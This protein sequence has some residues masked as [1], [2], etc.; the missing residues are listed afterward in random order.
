[1]LRY[2]Y[3]LILPDSQYGRK[4]SW[5]FVASSF[6][7]GFYALLMYFFY[8]KWDKN[9]NKARWVI[10]NLLRHLPILTLLQPL[11]QLNTVCGM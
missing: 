2:V 10:S 3:S 5:P 8:N 9:Y 4:T 11:S 6:I 1:M 7:F